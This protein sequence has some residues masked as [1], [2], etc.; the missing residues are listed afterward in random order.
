LKQITASQLLYI[1]VDFKTVLDC[2]SNFFVADAEISKQLSHAA[3]ESVQDRSDRKDREISDEQSFGRD[4]IR[5][6]GSH[7]IMRRHCRGDTA[8]REEA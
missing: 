1:F 8:T 7:K 4:R 6:Y 5:Q 3:A 2:R